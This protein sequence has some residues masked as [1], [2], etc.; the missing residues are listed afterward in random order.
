MLSVPEIDNVFED[1]R[2]KVR[3]NVVAHR[4]LSEAE[5]KIAVRTYLDLKKLKPR[6]NAEVTIVTSIGRSGGG[7]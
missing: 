2:R 5:I 7:K 6:R 3:Y 4:K 1:S